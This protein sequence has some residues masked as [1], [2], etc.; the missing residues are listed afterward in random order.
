MLL[1]LGGCSSGFSV[2]VPW[3]VVDDAPIELRDLAVGVQS[4]TPLMIENTG[5]APV[6]VRLTPEPPLRVSVDAFTLQAGAAAPISLHLRPTDYQPVEATLQIAA[7]SQQFTIPVSATVATDYDNDGFVALGAGGDDCDDFR[8]D[9]YPGAPE[10]CDGVDNNCD[11]Q[12][13]VDAVDAL[14]FYRDQDRDG[15]GDPSIHSRVCEAP[16]GFVARADDCDD[17]RAD[18]NP[19][20]IEITDG[21]DQNCNRLVDE[22]LLVERS[23]PITEVHLSDLSGDTIDYIEVR[24]RSSATLHLVQVQLAVDDAVV[25]LP[26]LTLDAA[27]L[28]VFCGVGDPGMIAGEPCDAPLPAPLTASA[29]VSLTAIETFESISLEGLPHAPGRSAELDPDQARAGRSGDPEDW[30]SATEPL[31]DGQFGT[32]WT[33]EGHCEG[34]W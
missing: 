26:A 22:H 18:I 29:R 30:C 25:S 16:P 27:D 3:L 33:L 14:D 21:I 4:R 5:T 8:G 13:D 31:H 23:L 6:R 32:P 12:I 17:T 20:A 1:A 34:G 10:V 9:V 2:G 19:G 28:A 24:G 15:Y 11:G 7:G